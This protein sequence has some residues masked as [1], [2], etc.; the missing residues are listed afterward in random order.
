ME[1]KRMVNL[2]RRVRHDYDNQLQVMMGYIDLGKPELA[3]EYMLAQVELHREESRLFRQF[4]AEAALYFYEQI[5]LC[6]DLGVIL[7]YKDCQVDSHA[8]FEKAQEPYRSLK[9]LS[10]K[11]LLSVSED[12]LIYATVTAKDGQGQVDFFGPGLG[13]EIKVQIEE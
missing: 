3:R 7:R 11:A 6:G 8:V 10:E 1:G 13:G 12:P 5:L 4:A 2:L 9:Q